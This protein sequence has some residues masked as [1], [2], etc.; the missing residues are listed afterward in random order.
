MTETR[1]TGAAA[2][3]REPNVERIA[4]HQQ[5]T[6]VASLHEW[7]ALHR[8]PFERWPLERACRGWL[9]L[10]VSRAVADALRTRRAGDFSPAFRLVCGEFGV[11][12]DGFLK[13]RARRRKTRGRLSTTTGT[14]GGTV[15]GM[16]TPTPFDDLL[17]RFKAR[18]RAAAAGYATALCA[19]PDATEE[20]APALGAA[21]EDARREMFTAHALEHALRLCA[22]RWGDAGASFEGWRHFFEGG[23]FAELVGALAGAAFC[24]E[25]ALIKTIDRE[26]ERL[27]DQA[28]A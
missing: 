21:F 2:I 18:T 24:D 5:P 19:L 28:G 14:P 13:A 3:G 8:I 16:D 9:D 4:R 11:N 17:A 23:G 10:A 12:P 25:L 22:G 6:E 20:T 27:E 15:R 26:W 1:R 7:C